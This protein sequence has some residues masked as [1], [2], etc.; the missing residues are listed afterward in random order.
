MEYCSAVFACGKTDGQMERQD[1]EKVTI[2]CFQIFTAKAPTNSLLAGFK[3]V[4][5]K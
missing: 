2:E 5:T 4:I 1:T 3:L